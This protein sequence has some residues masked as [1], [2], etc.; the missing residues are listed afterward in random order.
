MDIRIKQ[1]GRFS[2]ENNGIYRE[3]S[4]DRIRTPEE[5]NQYLRVTSPGVWMFLLAVVALLVGIFIW[6]YS[7][8]LTTRVTCGS[9]VESGK[10]TV[11]VRKDDIGSVKVGQEIRINGIV[12]AVTNIDQ[13]PFPVTD[14]MLEY[15][16]Y[17][18]GLNKGEFVCSVTGSIQVDDGIYSA[19]IITSSVSPFYFITN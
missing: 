14:D 19:D 9:Q 11:L 8:K 17:M 16:L 5:L 10:V 2:M 15:L 6:A 4:L 7:G 1:K 13:T 12:G 18:G 3:K